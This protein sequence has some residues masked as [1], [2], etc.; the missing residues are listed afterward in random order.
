MKLFSPTKRWQLIDVYYSQFQA[1]QPKIFIEN[2]VLHPI[3]VTVSFTQTV[4]PRKIESTKSHTKALQILSYIP[5]FVKMDRA[6][7]CLK[8]FIVEDSMESIPS[9]VS[10]IKAAFLKDLI[11]QIAGLAGSLSAVGRPVGMAKNIGGGVHALFYEVDYVVVNFD[12]M[13]IFYRNIVLCIVV[14]IG[15]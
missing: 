10:H 11:G 14:Y 8:S 9:L 6:V 3:K 2:F 1:R 13:I 12:G 4:L 5:S 15:K 7:I